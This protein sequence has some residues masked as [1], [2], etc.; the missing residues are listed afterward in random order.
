MKYLF[1]LLAVLIVMGTAVF[2][3]S[4]DELTTEDLWSGSQLELFIKRTKAINECK[5]I[6]PWIDD[7]THRV[8]KLE[9]QRE[10]ERN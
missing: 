5:A 2:I 8:I 1:T 4:R 3:I 10:K 7:L 6:K 9:M